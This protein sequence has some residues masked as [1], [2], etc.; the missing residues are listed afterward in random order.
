MTDHMSNHYDRLI[1]QYLGLESLEFTETV[2]NVCGAAIDGQVLPLLKQRLQEEQEQI[3][4]LHAHGYLR[5][6]EK[7]E[8]MV[9]VLIPLIAALSATGSEMEKP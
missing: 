6:R 3:P 9:A 1:E 8:Q 7:S 5:L 2:L 4:Q